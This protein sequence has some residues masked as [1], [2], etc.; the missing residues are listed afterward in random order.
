LT[1]KGDNVLKDH[2]HH[3]HHHHHHHRIYFRLPETP[4]KPIALA[5]INLFY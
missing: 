3:H 1:P 2:Q 5:T 4:Q